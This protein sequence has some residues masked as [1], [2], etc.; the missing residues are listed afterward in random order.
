[1]DM[2]ARIRSSVRTTISSISVKPRV[3]ERETGSSKFEIGNLKRGTGCSEFEIGNLKREAG[4]SKFEIGNWERETG[5]SEFEI[6]NLR[7]EIR[8]G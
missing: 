4:S 3:L 5:S 2:V 6:C 8:R 7:F 1:M